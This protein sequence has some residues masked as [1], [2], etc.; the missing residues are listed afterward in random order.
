[1]T[2]PDRQTKAQR[3]NAAREKA[4]IM[5]EE[6]KRK[7]RRNRFILQGSIGVVIIAVI[8]VVVIVIVNVSRPTSNAGPRNMISDGIVLTSSTTYVA[9]PGIAHNGKPTPT[10]QQDDGKAHITIY[11]DLQCPIC[12]QFEQANSAQIGQ[13]LDAGTATYEIHPI[14]LPNLD[15]ASNGNHYSSRAASAIGCVAQYSPSDF[16]AVNTAFYANQPEENGHGKTDAQILATIKKGGASSAAITDCVH[17]E[18]FKGWVQAASNRAL[19]GTSIPNSSLK[20]ITG[21]PTIIVNGHQYQPPT[22]SQGWAD[23]A[24]FETFVKTTVSGWSPDGSGATASPSPSP[25]G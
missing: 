22:G 23:T 11:E 21:T 20:Q 19:S 3:Q 14:S 18:K 8:V 16:F 13:W 9:T 6:A 12:Q 17:E 5:R 2:N 4:R 1:M 15:A 10:T 25:A 24:A 7:A